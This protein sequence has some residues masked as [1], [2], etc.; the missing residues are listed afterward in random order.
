MRC[1]DER[2]SIFDLFVQTNR[3]TSNNHAG[4]QSGIGGPT[5]ADATGRVVQPRQRRHIDR[6]DCAFESM[7][8]GEHVNSSGER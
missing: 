1:N 8:K 6:P 2:S 3:G 7:K 4:R 5:L